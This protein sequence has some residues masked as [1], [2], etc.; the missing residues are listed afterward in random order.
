MRKFLGVLVSLVLIGCSSDTLIGTETKGDKVGYLCGGYCL[1]AANC[2]GLTWGNFEER[3]ACQNTCITSM[4]SNVN[5]KETY[6]GLDETIDACYV[7][8]VFKS[9]NVQGMPLPCLGIF[10]D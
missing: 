4:C 2:G 1:R 6:L 8:L 3:Q 10:D 5:C 7:L 9:C